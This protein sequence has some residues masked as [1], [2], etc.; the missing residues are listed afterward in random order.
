MN[1]TIQKVTKDIFFDEAKVWQKFE[2]EIKKV[3]TSHNI[4]EIRVPVFEATE[5]FA[6]GVG[7]ETDIVTKEMYT[8]KD[9]A[10]RYIR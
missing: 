5:L 8:F 3:C 1:F 6:R 2:E 10:E 4:F 9:R 7:D